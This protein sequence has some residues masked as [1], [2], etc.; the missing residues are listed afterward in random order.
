M[1]YHLEYKV[2]NHRI[3]GRKSQNTRQKIT[4][5]KVENHRI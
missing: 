2:E 1:S 3:Q 4:E 5:Y